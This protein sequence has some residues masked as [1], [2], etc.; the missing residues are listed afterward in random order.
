MKFDTFFHGLLRKSVRRGDPC[1]RAKSAED[2]L[3]TGML[4]ADLLVLADDC[5]PYAKFC[6][7][8]FL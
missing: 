2:V 3:A 1:N 6:I 5:T 7:I 8:C 4:V